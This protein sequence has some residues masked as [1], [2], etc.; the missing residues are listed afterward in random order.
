MHDPY[1]IC[2]TNIAF[3]ISLEVQSLPKLSCAQTSSI[4][5]GLNVIDL[6]VLKFGKRPFL[7]FAGFPFPRLP[8]TTTLANRVSAIKL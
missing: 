6:C 7:P 3:Q 8:L 4:F 2:I 5:T 1:S